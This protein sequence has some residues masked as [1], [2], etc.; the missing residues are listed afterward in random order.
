MD[1]WA[2]C[3]NSCNTGQG[4]PPEVIEAH[5]PPLV[6]HQDSKLTLPPVPLAFS[7]SSLSSFPAGIQRL[8]SSPQSFEVRLEL[9]R[10]ISLRRTL[11]HGGMLWRR[12]PLSLRPEQRSKLYENSGLVK[13]YDVFLSHTWETPGYL[14]CISIW[15][16]CSRHIVLICWLLAM[17]LGIFLCTQ[18]VLPLEYSVRHWALNS[19]AI[20]TGPW[21][22]L[23]GL[24]LSQ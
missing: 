13:Q 6:E 19:V 11:H 21:V 10:A 14:K 15:V 9:A 22:M 8:Q 18:D 12:S 7:I 3:C 23:L 4:A 2:A 16:R 20:S 5:A 1:D 24:L 17:V